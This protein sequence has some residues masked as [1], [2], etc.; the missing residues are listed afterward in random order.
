M[1]FELGVGEIEAV[2]CATNIFKLNSDPAIFIL[3]KE[4]ISISLKDLKGFKVFA[5]VEIQLTL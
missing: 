3:R 1:V 2:F 5:I 4:Q